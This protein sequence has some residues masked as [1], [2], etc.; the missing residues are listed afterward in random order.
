MN[1]CPRLI[2]LVLFS[3]IIAGCREDARQTDE[4]EAV[5]ESESQVDNT[6]I[7]TPK[8]AV[9]IG[10]GDDAKAF[11]YFN[12]INHSY[13]FGTNHKDEEKEISNDSMRL[14]L[15]SL[16]SPQFM[17]IMAI[18]DNKYYRTKFFIKPG[19]TVRFEMKDGKIHSLGPDDPENSFY[20]DLYDATPDYAKNN[21]SGDIQE[22]G[23]SI[24]A[25]YQKKLEFLRAYISDNKD[26][27]ENAISSIRKDLKYEYFNNLIQP[28]NI[29]SS[30][31]EF[32]FNEQDG[33]LP[34]LQRE[35]GKSET[36][37]SYS[38]YFGSIDVQD[39]S[40]NPDITNT[41]YKN[42]INPFIRYYFLSSENLPYTKEKFLAEKQFIEE[43]FEGEVRDYAIAR[44]IS[45][46]HNKGFGSSKNNIQTLKSAISEYEPRFEKDSYKSRMAEI[47][48]EL[49]NF[50]FELSEEV[51]Q[52]ELVTHSGARITLQEIL[53]QGPELKILDLWA[54]WCPPCIRDIRETS[55]LKEELKEIAD[56]QWIYL[57]LDTT[58]EKWKKG[59]QDLNP[60]LNSSNSF[61]IE[62]HFESDLV[63]F[64]KVQSIPR[65]IILD[66]DNSI[67]LDNAP[68]PF[69][70]ENFL[71]LIKSISKP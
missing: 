19:E 31:R 71:R 44:M 20:Q 39:F 17:E 33:L 12:V 28:R 48:D 22:Y 18:G 3:L 52:S 4:Q 45:D 27:T 9:L 21:Y 43:H 61:W 53:K 24:A 67:I 57:S 1:K 60:N 13:L 63:K 30:N 5:L 34:I 56:I 11:K 51:L 16:D 59:V 62:N 36:M 40:T 35:A 42:S 55:G 7:S 10:K 15:N 25:I 50:N 49:S 29:P 46:Y 2:F 70:K 38:E 69:V 68:S 23:K 54:S 37:F 65:Y 64:F 6:E 32:Y 14:K 66:Q 8:P 26:L 41:F 58:T 47:S